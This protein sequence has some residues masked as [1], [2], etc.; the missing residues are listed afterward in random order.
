MRKLVLLAGMALLLLAAEMPAR[1][2]SVSGVQG[3]NGGVAQLF[4]LSGPG[5]LYVDSQGTQGYMYTPAP[6]VEMFNFRTPNGP[7]WSGAMMTLG[8]RLSVG[9]ISGA[10]QGFFSS[11]TGTTV[12]SRF[13]TVFPS[14]PREPP[15][16]SPIQSGILEDIP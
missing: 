2:Q 15:L 8:P 7:V 14:P 13:P 11:T 4:D 6:N 5:S 9:L 12:L 10:N 16:L 1:A 3:L